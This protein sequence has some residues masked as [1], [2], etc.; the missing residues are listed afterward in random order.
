MIIGLLCTGENKR[1]PT[2]LLTSFE[3][4]LN[5]PVDVVCQRTNMNQVCS[6]H[7]MKVSHAPCEDE[8]L[9]S[10]LK[11]FWNYEPLG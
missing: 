11:R 3:Y 8:V 6:S 1:G 10:D 5:G 4:V 9:C 7:V 2:A